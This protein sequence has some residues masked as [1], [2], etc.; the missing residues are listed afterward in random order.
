M[1]DNWINFCAQGLEGEKRTESCGCKASFREA[2]LRLQVPTA[3]SAVILLNVD[4]ISNNL[5][6]LMRIIARIALLHKFVETQF[7]LCKKFFF[8]RMEN[9][10]KMWYKFCFW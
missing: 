9:S 2:S 7:A 3:Q 4:S 8:A 10:K 5:K 1:D 6:K